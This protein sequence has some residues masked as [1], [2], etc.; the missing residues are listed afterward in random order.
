MKVYTRDQTE[1]FFKRFLKLYELSKMKKFTS[2]N[3]QD[4]RAK[5]LDSFR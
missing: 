3:K 5:H 2:N 4:D 1:S